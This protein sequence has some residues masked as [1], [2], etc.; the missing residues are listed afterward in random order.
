[1]KIGVYG[2]TFDP[3]H[4]GHM[5]AA[6]QIKAR[7]GL[8]KL[9][10]IPAKQPPHKALDD[11]SAPAEDRLV[12]TAMMADGIPPADSVAADGQELQREGASYTAD[13]VEA[14]AAQYPGDELWLVM[15]SDMFLSF[16]TWR[17]PERICAVAGICGFTRS[18]REELVP[19]EE[20]ARRL[21][22]S[23][24]ARAMA[25]ALPEVVDVSSSQVRQL[26]AAGELQAASG[27]LWSQVF[28][29]ILRKGL[30]GVKVDLAH[31]PDDQLRAVSYSM[32]RAKRIPHVQGTEEE[33]VKLARRWGADV[34]HARRA[35]I[36][37]DCT[38][39]YTVEEHFAVCRRYG[40]ELDEL[41][42][43]SEK[44]LHAKTGAALA[45]HVFGE[46][47]EEQ[48]AIYYHTTGKGDMTLLE[49]IIYLA[50]YMEP[51]RDFPGV[52]RLR[53][54]AYTDL[55]AAVALG[56][57]MSIAEMEEKGREVHPNTRAALNSLQHGKEWEHE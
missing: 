9:L 52:E 55:D 42:R 25:V 30:Y 34:D 51:H 54:L 36:L 20:Q 24:G 17:T 48:V 15:G 35:A 31:L 50:D 12:M 11:A 7:L 56:C 44:L 49:K 23:L 53:A 10:L 5:A 19:L 3:P 33:A 32:M 29:Y 16:H 14:L 45:C 28:G 40:V 38:K 21:S 37:H 46:P 57:E 2:G 41:E 6:T 26:L 1:M 43:Q 47:L 8:D 22:Q 39:Y 4:L 13:T 27:L 18:P